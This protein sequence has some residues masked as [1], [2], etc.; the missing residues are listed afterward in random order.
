MLYCSVCGKEVSENANF[1]SNCGYALG[2]VEETFSVSSNDLIQKVK[3][4]IHEGNVT[5]IIIKNEEGKTLL[6]IPVTI[7][8]IGA[9]LVPWLAAIEAIAALATKCTIVVQRRKPSP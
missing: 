9:V 6:E 4:L 1:C 7:G 8:V 3:E 5:N 2:M